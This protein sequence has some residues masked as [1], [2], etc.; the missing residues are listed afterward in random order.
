[1]PWHSENLAD[2]SMEIGI[3]LVKFERRHGTSNLRQWP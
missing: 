2:Q 1:M 3:P